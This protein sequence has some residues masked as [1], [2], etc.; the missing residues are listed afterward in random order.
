[1]TGPVS[2]A[3]HKS[4]PTHEAAWSD[5]IQKL[6]VQKSRIEPN[7]TGENNVNVMLTNNTLLYSKIGA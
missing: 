7:K 2:H 5:K 4:E 6:L 1:M 3:Y